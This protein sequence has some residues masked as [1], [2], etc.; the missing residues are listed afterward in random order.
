VLFLS[1][2]C[3]AQT[4][5]TPVILANSEG[6]RYD[7]KFGT[8][9]MKVTSV[10][11]AG[12]WSM[13]DFTASPG[14]QTMLHRHPKTD[15][16]FFVLEGELTMYVDGKLS[17]LHHGDMAYVPKMTS[18]SFANLS[19]QPVRFLGTFTPSGFENSSPLLLKR[20]KP[21]RREHRNMRQLC[22]KSTSRLITSLLGLRPSASPDLR[23]TNW[24]AN[25]TPNLLL[26]RRGF[27][28]DQQPGER[29]SDPDF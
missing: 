11:T 16:T 23:L 7:L 27:L 12:T 26:A 2:T 21:T 18:H 15:E 20:A 4:N 9:I 28:A 14:V 22:R 25:L 13:V 10:Q 17:T 3:I 8:A 5:G 24:T 29:G 1:A 19:D 6:E